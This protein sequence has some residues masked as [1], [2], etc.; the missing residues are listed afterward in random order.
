MK[1]KNSIKQILKIWMQP[2]YS[3]LNTSR[4]YVL[5]GLLV[6]F[7]L[8]S[9]LLYLF[10]PDSRFDPKYLHRQKA[11]IGLSGYF[12]DIFLFGFGWL[13]SALFLGAS[14]FTPSTAGLVPYQSRHLQWAIGIPIYLISAFATVIGYASTDNLADALMIGLFVLSVLLM[15]AAST[16]SKWVGIAMVVVLQLPNLFIQFHISDQINQ[17]LLNLLKKDLQIFLNIGMIGTSFLMTFFVLRWI[18]K[19]GDY[20]FDVNR[21]KYLLAAQ[22]ASPEIYF[23]QNWTNKIYLIATQTLGRR[24]SH[25]DDV[26]TGALG[27]TGH[28]TQAASQIVLFIVVDVLWIK[29]LPKAQFNMFHL[30]TLAFVFVIIRHYTLLQDVIYA[31]RTEMSLINLAPNAPHPKRQTEIVLRYLSR[32]FIVVWI[33]IVVLQS[34]DCF[35]LGVT[36]DATAPEFLVASSLLIPMCWLIRDYRKMQ[37]QKDKKLLWVLVIGVL[38]FIAFSAFV[39]VTP[40]LSWQ[41]SLLMIVM[42]AAVVWFRWKSVTKVGVLFPAGRAV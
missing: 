3:Q 19:K 32:Q 1:F 35:L 6:I 25:V 21:K 5:I 17:E 39:V 24:F 12:I 31:A 34:I 42:I 26:V 15:F 28:W 27:P 20:L 40:I 11:M 29:F 37:T 14:Q 38:S 9:T 13:T 7:P 18:Y 16:R 23:S 2:I 36:G 30:Y 10:L 33:G 22:K 41:A 8:I 4:K